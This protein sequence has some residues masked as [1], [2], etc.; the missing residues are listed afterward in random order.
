MIRIILPLCEHDFPLVN[1]LG[2]RFIDFADMKQ[3]HLTVIAC[4]RDAFEVPNFCKKIAPYF[5]QADYHVIPDVPF[6][7]EEWPLGANH[8]FY[9]T[10]QLLTEQ[11]NKDPWLFCEPDLHPLWAGWLDAFDKEY[12][13]AGKP[14]FGPI[15]VTR[16]RDRKTGGPVI[17]G[18]HMVGCGVYPPD[19]FRTC[20][21]VHFLTDLPYDVAIQEE[22]VSQCHDTKLIFHGFQTCNYKV[23]DGQIIGEDVKKPDP[24]GGIRHFY[25]GRP[26]P[27]GTACI[28]GAKDDSLEKIPQEIL[29]AL[30][31]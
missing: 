7:E 26:I 21:A 12:D 5:Q 8:L 22:S 2:Q 25:G 18:Q 14:Y 15:N 28:H 4:W 10:A 9:H 6:G 17:R 1:L 19:F 27:K 11:G 31:P 23:I 16:F 30:R 13:A 24:A 29:D 20:K 3:R